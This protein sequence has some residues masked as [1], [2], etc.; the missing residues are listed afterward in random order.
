MFHL[1]P[2]KIILVSDH[3][4]Y[5]EALKM[6]L[7]SANSEFK[8]DALA[9]NEPNCLALITENCPEIL[10][11]DTIIM[12]KTIWNFLQDI[13]QACPSIKIIVLANNKEKIY[14]ENAKKNGA[15]GYVLK[16]SPKEILVAAIKIVIRDGVFFDPG[17]ISNHKNESYEMIKEKYNLSNRELEIVILIKDGMTSKDVAAALGIS[18]HTVEAHR[19]NVYNK[20]KINKVTELLKIL[21]E[22]ED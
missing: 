18:H 2:H 6:L 13:H 4:I 12:G 22:P 19:K 7:N 1:E 21:A 11:L 15:S 9:M 16:S 14:L 3:D 20:L 10:L 8:V 5:R 17:I